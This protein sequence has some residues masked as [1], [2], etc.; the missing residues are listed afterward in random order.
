M[1]LVAALHLD[2]RIKDE[3]YCRSH[4]SD[5]ACFRLV[6]DPNN[7]G[8]VVKK[9]MPW[10]FETLAEP[11]RN[12]LARLFNESTLKFRRGLQQH[13]VLVASTYEC[14]YQDGQVFHISSEEGI[15][16][17]TAVS[18]ASPAQ[19][20]MLLNRIIQA[21]YGVL[22]QDESLS[23]GLDPQLDNFGMKICPASGDI[24]VAYIDV[25]P[26]LCFFE[27]RHL[28]HYPNPTDQK[29]IK[30]ELSRKF[31]PL[32]ILRRLRFSVLS[33]DISLEEIFLKCLKDGLSGQLYRQALEFFESL[34]D[35]VIKNGFD[36]AAVGKQIE[37]IPLDGIDDIREVGMRLA[38]RADCPRRHFLAEVFDLSRKDSSPGH[39][40][41]H[42]V[43]FEQLKKKLLSL[44]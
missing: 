16:A 20:I 43:R 10:L 17:Q 7:S 25:F 23:V 21:I 34:P 13:G 6:D 28:V 44:L 42:E 14:L 32:G 26:P 4:F 24:T 18:Q 36:S 35:A 5:V 8:V 39:E 38:Q 3:W 31:R 2:E 37:G 33:I 30:W 12:D 41:E 22:Y 15:T 29:V 1:K 9:I 27:G 11:E 19:R 40:E